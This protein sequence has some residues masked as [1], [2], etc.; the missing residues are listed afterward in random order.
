VNKRE[1]KAELYFNIYDSQY[2]DKAQKARLIQAAGHRVH[3]EE[4]ILIMTC[5]EERL[6][7]A[8]KEK[9]IHH[10]RQ[11]LEQILPEPKK[12]VAT[13]IPKRVK[14]ERINEKKVQGQKKSLRQK[15]RMEDN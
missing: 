8:N 2:L 7:E 13:K 15:P 1:T 9:V 3:H 14:E 4:H 10:F 5:Q 6:Q 11:L 12:R